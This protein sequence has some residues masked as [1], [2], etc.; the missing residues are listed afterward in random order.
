MRALPHL[1]KLGVREGLVIEG[2]E[3]R[4]STGKGLE[5]ADGEASAGGDFT[6]VPKHLQ[7][8]ARQSMWAALA[9]MAACRIPC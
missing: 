9:C 2:A 3:V 6:G 8:H 4:T 1:A 5:A 7:G